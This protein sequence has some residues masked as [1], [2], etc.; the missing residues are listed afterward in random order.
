LNHALKGKKVICYPSNA[1]NTEVRL[2]Y[3]TMIMA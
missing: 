3:K 1:G 2:L